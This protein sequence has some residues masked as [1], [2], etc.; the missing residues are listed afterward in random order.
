MIRIEEKFN[1]QDIERED[2]G[3]AV[4]LTL[5][6]DPDQ[7]T[8]VFVRIQSWDQTCFHKEIRELFDAASGK[9]IRVTIEVV[10]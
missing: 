5:T 8:G 4:I 10:D 9:S 2:G 3:Q 6:G 1:P 7:E